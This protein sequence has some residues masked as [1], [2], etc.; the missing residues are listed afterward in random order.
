MSVAADTKKLEKMGT[1]FQD[2]QHVV[3]VAADTKKLEKMG[4]IF[5]TSSVL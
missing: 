4:T 5:K 2:I 3:S 1:I